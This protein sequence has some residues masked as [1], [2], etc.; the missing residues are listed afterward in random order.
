VTGDAIR[1]RRSSLC[2]AKAVRWDARHGELLVV[3][4]LTGRVYFGRVAD[5]GALSLV[6]SY[7]VRLS[8]LIHGSRHTLATSS[9]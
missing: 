8:L 9:S 4:I 2:S 1:A 6:R 3:D 5:E 7:R